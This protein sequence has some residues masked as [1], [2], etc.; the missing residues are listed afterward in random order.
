M[1]DLTRLGWFETLRQLRADW[2]FQR[3]EAPSWS[4]C[5]LFPGCQDALYGQAVLHEL[6]GIA[7]IWLGIGPRPEGS[8]RA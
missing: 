4:R 6:T 5:T 7:A 8:K 1:I 3:P 2:S